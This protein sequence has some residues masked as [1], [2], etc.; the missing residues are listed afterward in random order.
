MTIL[1][2]QGD[3]AVE[4]YFG[5]PVLTEGPQTENLRALVR[6][7][8]DSRGETISRL[9]IAAHGNYANGTELH[10]FLAGRRRI[11]PKRAD[12]L[13]RAITNYPKGF[14]HSAPMPAMAYARSAEYRMQKELDANRDAA[15]NARAAHI[16][17]CRQ[18]EIA[19]YGFTTITGDVMDQ[20][21]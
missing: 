5:H 16:E 10:D 19:K 15:K 20:V 1:T 17:A 2:M 4:T 8:I 13:V 21:A 7:H 11:S 18:A 9:A 6:A 12:A 3:W 14:E